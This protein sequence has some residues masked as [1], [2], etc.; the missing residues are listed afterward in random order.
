MDHNPHTKKRVVLVIDSDHRRSA[1]LKKILNKYG[2]R[3]YTATNLLEARRT[4]AEK[5]K[6]DV[7]LYSLKRFDLSLESH[8]VFFQQFGYFRIDPHRLE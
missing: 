6:I 4:L 5:K 3:V 2:Y 7:A 1:K 8:I